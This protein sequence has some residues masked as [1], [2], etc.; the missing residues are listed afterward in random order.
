ML[1]SFLDSLFALRGR[2]NV[3]LALTADHGVAPIPE[4][5][6]TWGDNSRASRL[7]SRDLEPVTAGVATLIRRLRLDGTAFN[8]D[9]SVLEV[10]RSKVQGKDAEV[11][12]VAR[13]FARLARR[14][15]GIQRVDVIDDINRADTVRDATA[16]RWLHMFRPGGEVIAAITLEPY[17]LYGSSIATHGSPHDYDAKVPVLFWGQAFSPGIDSSAARV[18]DMAPT[19]AHLLGVRPLERLD[20]IVLSRAFKR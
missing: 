6:S 15:P 1:G 14:I 10:D 4:V 20:G 11:R 9:W 3:V 2:E 16:R 12:E 13:E 7:N 8:L 17:W 18:V 19:L 5:R